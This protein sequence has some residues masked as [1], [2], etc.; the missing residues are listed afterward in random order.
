M[1]SGVSEEEAVKGVANFTDDTTGFPIDDIIKNNYAK[2][3]ILTI[4]T[5]EAFNA[6]NLDAKNLVKRIV[7][8]NK[9][10][11]DSKTFVT[12]Q[13]VLFENFT[14]SLNTEQ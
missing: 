5:I 2:M 4:Q 10:N 12:F 8:R 9:I 3:P 1:K 11:V 7:E 13:E 6:G 14:G